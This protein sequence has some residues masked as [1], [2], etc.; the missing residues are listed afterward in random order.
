[1]NRSSKKRILILVVLFF[2]IDAAI[3]FRI[4][5][6]EE[7][8]PFRG[9]ANLD[10]YLQGEFSSS[11]KEKGLIINQESTDGNLYMRYRKGYGKYW[12]ER[13]IRQ[14][15]SP[16]GLISEFDWNVNNGFNVILTHPIDGNRTL[17][18][19]E[20]ERKKAA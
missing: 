7:T 18:F 11:L 4:Y 8:S 5:F 20:D 19:R 10:S 15:L 13:V 9:F 14:S 1:M 6:R 2:I 17:K 12:L 3:I 16:S